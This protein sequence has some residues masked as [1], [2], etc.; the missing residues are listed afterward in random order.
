MRV[1]VRDAR[2][3]L[4]QLQG[5][6]PEIYIFLKGA[7]SH[8]RTIEKRRPADLLKAGRGKASPKAAPAADPRA[9]LIHRQR[10]LVNAML[11][12]I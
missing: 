10:S 2:P 7:Q 1:T 4:P 9:E 11:C 3:S 6:R 8:M 12:M 5:D